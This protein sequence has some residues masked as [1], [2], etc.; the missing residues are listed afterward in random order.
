MAVAMAG[1]WSRPV[2]PLFT[3]NVEKL[4]DARRRSPFTRFLSVAPLPC[5]AGKRLC[6]MAGQ[7]PLLRVI[8][9]G[10]ANTAGRTCRSRSPVAAVA[11][12]ARSVPGPLSVVVVT[13]TP[14]STP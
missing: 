1:L 14:E 12:A 7:V 9:C 5:R 10:V 13:T 4:L 6:S 3:V 11:S 2:T 8:V